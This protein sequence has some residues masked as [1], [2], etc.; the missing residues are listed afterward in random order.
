MKQ[1][2][3]RLIGL[4]AYFF[5]LTASAEAAKAAEQPALGSGMMAQWMLLAA[6]AFLV[7]FMVIR[8][9]SKRAKEHRELVTGLQKG[10]EVITNGGLLGKIARVTDNFFVV[11]LAEGIEVLVQK[12]AVAG[13]MPKGTMKSI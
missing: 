6:F 1:L 13:L 9:Q 3:V 7:Y 12:Q 4:T 10:D 11:S 2:W 5:T 8:P